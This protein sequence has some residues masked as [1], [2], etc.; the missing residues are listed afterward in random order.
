MNEN[1]IKKSSDNSTFLKYLAKKD[2][3]MDDVIT[4]FFLNYISK[5]MSGSLYSS[6]DYLPQNL[7]KIYYSNI[8]APRFKNMWDNFKVE[9]IENENDLEN[10]H[11]TEEREG[12][13]SVY[14]YIT[15]R[16]DYNNI[17]IYQLCKIH[18]L[19]FSK[20]PHPEFGGNFR[21]EEIY[22]PN[23]GVETADWRQIPNE[24]V[25][26]YLETKPLIK[27]GI[28]LGQNRNP[29]KIITYINDC[30]DLNCR[31]IK[32]HPFAD[33]NGRA[34]RA[35]TNL[36][37]KLANIPPVFVQSKEK[38]KYGKAMNKAIVAE[39][40]QELRKFYYY[41]ICDSIIELDI[42]KRENLK[43]IVEIEE[44]KTK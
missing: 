25:K 4:L 36:M 13:G 24:M 42:L 26:L 22:L 34:T 27:K 29:E 33:G 9:Y 12:L 15:L 40:Q 39:D 30:L 11:S 20:V 8:T 14:D 18:Q 2:M 44:G 7:I 3:D 35:F 17:D 10:V 31:I 41:K 23:S 21:T 43:S 37:F 32:M 5:G 16:N 38:D 6:N 28:E 1:N 19:L